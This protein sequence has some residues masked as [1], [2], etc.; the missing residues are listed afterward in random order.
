[1]LLEDIHISYPG[2]ATKGM[3]YVPLW[4][5]GD[6]PE[7]IDKYPEFTMFGELPAWG[8]YLRHIRH[9]TLKDVKLSLAD[10]DFRP[11]IVDDDVEFLTFSW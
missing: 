4:R 2:R 3:A 1:V 11:M 8:L 7:Q 9:I 5:K 6:V 10:D